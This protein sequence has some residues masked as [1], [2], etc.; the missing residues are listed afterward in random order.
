ML[1]IIS[2]WW[3]LL[4]TYVFFYFVLDS[5]WRR[6][7][8]AETCRISVY[9]KTCLTA[10]A[11]R[12]NYMNNKLPLWFEVQR[13]YSLW[14]ALTAINSDC[15]CEVWKHISSVY[16][17]VPVPD[18]ADCGSAKGLPDIRWREVTTQYD[19]VCNVSALQLLSTSFG[20]HIL[21]QQK[22]W[23][24]VFRPRFDRDPQLR[25]IFITS[26]KAIRRSLNCA[27]L[28]LHCRQKNHVYET[29]FTGLVQSVIN[30]SQQSP[31]QTNEIGSITMRWNYWT[32]LSFEILK[33][34]N[35]FRH[36]LICN[37]CILLL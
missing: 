20:Y 5:P 35:V 7:T 14:E 23:R 15:F 6:L 1:Y 21:L 22:T 33:F 28:T 37:V 25:T 16:I 12:W 26:L 32:K 3:I 19:S 27:K 2:R 34:V 29:P 24:Q 30:M 31:L 10:S 9:H 8:E 11:I 18:S 17:G 4:F 36:D 13:Q